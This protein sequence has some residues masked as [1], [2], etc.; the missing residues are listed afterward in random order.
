MP[1]EFLA[2]NSPPLDFSKIPAY[3]GNINQHNNNYN[4]NN[5]NNN[6]N[7]NNNNNNNNSNIKNIVI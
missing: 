4:N 2:L 6:S 3:N 1:L 7:N 5:N